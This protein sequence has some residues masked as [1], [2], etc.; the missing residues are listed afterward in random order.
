MRPHLYRFTD[1][2][3][4]QDEFDEAYREAMAALKEPGVP[5][6]IHEPSFILP[7]KGEMM[8]RNNVR[9]DSFCKLEVG[10]G[11]YIGEFVHIASFSHIGGGG[12][13]TEIEEYVGI[14]SG[15]KVISGTNRIDRISPSI[16]APSSLMGAKRCKTVIKR[17]AFLATNAVVLPGVT[18]GEGA[19]LAAGAVATKDIPAW[20]I[21][22]GVPAVFMDR[23]VVRR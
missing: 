15:V 5:M 8:I 7:G 18:I 2:P 13:I 9:I 20:E 16:S 17:F 6:V 3:G 12:G 11:L 14:S 19:V 23:R 22:G 10:Q 1:M 4:F 21:W